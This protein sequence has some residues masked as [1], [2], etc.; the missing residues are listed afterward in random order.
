MNAQL[1]DMVRVTLRGGMRLVLSQPE[2]IEPWIPLGAAWSCSVLLEGKP[3]VMTGWLPGGLCLHIAT[4]LKSH[5]ALPG[6]FKAAW[7]RAQELALAW[8][9][10]GEGLRHALSL[11]YS[12]AWVATG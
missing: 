5:P 4:R 11:P 3:V 12:E 6:F 9:Q 2:P 1:P 10:R 7:P 8:M